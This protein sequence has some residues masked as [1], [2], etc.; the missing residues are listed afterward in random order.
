MENTPIEPSKDY[1]NMTMAELNL[2]LENGDDKALQYVR[3]Y[4]KRMENLSN[5]RP[6]AIAAPPFDELAEKAK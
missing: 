3:D 5:Y 2:A 6:V 4:M 1:A